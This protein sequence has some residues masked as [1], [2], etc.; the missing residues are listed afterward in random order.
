MQPVPTV[1]ALSRRLLDQSRLRFKD[2]PGVSSVPHASQLVQSVPAVC[3]VCVYDVCVSACA[4][5]DSHK[6]FA[7]SVPAFLEEHRFREDTC[8][9]GARACRNGHMVNYST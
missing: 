6:L 9:A 7:V 1:C 5:C 4:R 3:A 8:S 2:T